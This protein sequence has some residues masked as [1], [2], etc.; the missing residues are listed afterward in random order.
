MASWTGYPLPSCDHHRQLQWFRVED[1]TWLLSY[2]REAGCPPSRSTHGEFGVWV[3][4]RV[5]PQRVFE[6]E[7]VRLLAWWLNWGMKRG[8]WITRRHPPCAFL[9][10]L[11][12]QEYAKLAVKRCTGGTELL[13][14]LSLVPERLTRAS[15][16]TIALLHLVISV[17]ARLFQRPI[18]YC[19]TNFSWDREESFCDPILVRHVWLNMFLLRPISL[20]RILPSSSLEDES[21]HFLRPWACLEQNLKRFFGKLRKVN[22]YLVTS[23]LWQSMMQRNRP[24]RSW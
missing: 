7:R 1:V 20:N 13:T 12:L 16:S 14:P 11:T 4:Q 19:H 18:V 22:S 3:F 5:V 17:L 2:G 21:V 6:L 15:L 24:T 9:R 23:W 8:R 10:N